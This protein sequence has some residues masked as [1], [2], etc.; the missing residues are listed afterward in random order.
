MMKGIRIVGLAILLIIFVVSTVAA[1]GLFGGKKDDKA[2]VDVDGL[3]KR[4]ASLLNNVQ[5]ATISFAEGIVLVQIAVGQKAEA[6]KLQQS[7]ANAKAKKGDKNATKALVGEVNNA[8]ASLN[9]VELASQMSK[10]KAQESLGSSILKI[11]IGVILDGFAAK[12]ASD[13]LQES[14]AA[15]K[16]VSWG[17]AGKVKEVID[18]A[19]FV[20]Q[21]IPPQANNLQQYSGKLIDY[22]K[23]N[24][25]SMPSQ[26]SIK[27]QADAKLAE[28]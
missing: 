1:Q 16:Q 20:V 28:G 6:E 22:G 11:G 27:K 21:E 19:Q 17:A 10:E 12:N 14:Q 18:V 13:L 3:S 9:K 25:I 15:L 8:T 2:K 7:I 5:S 4:S 24:G 23:T 26:E